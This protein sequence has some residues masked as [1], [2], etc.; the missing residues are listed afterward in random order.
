MT[1][2]IYYDIV[3]GIVFDLN[4]AILLVCIDFKIN[5]VKRGDFRGTDI[6]MDLIARS[7]E[8]CK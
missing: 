7:V 1:V 2:K 6:F 8:P 3:S 5:A 4:A